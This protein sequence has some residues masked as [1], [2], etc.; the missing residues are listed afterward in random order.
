MFAGAGDDFP[1]GR[2]EPV[3][4]A[5]DVPGFGVVSV[6]EGRELEPGDE[7]AG[8][9]GDVRPGLVGFEVEERQLAQA[10]VLQGFDP[11]LASATGAVPGVQEGSVPA[12]RVGQERGDAVPIGIEQGRLRSGVQRLCP[13]E[14]FRAGRVVLKRDNLG[15]VDDPRIGPLCAV[16][17]Q[18]RLQLALSLIQPIMW[19][20]PTGSV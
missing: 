8:Q 11:V 4:P 18:G 7:V 14:Q 15:G 12:G 10:G 1:G 16:L 17:V 20:L 9:G 6:R 3:A 2:E 19:A 13:E 5:F